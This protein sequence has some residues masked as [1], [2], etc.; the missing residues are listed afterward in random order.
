MLILYKIAENYKGRFAT[1]ATL[2]TSYPIASLA[3]YAY[4]NDTSSYWYWNS[5]LG[6]PAWVNQEITESAYLALSAATKAAVPYI[7]GV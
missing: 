1:A 3:S 2:Q 5:A 7:V 4:V 6:T